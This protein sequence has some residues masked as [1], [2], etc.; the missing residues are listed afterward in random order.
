MVADGV[1]AGVARLRDEVAPEVPDE[2]LARTLLAWTQLF[3][4]ISF[5][6]FGHLHGVI[7]NLDDLATHQAR[8]GA[9]LVAR[10]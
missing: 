4:G 6:L 9:H 5:E 10:G 2:V 8:R 1:A 3:G 7:T